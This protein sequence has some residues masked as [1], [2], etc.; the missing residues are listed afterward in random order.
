MSA[1]SV[2]SN[3]VCP[4]GSLKDLSAPCGGE[5]TRQR[6]TS[7]PPRPL[8]RTGHKHGRSNQDGGANICNRPPV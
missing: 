3:K 4:S 2:Q 1:L 5:R 6:Q 7:S 8:W